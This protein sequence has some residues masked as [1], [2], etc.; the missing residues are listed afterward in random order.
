[1]VENEKSDTALQ[2]QVETTERLLK[3]LISKPRITAVLLTKPPVKFI[4]DIFIEVSTATGCGQGLF[5]TAEMENMTTSRENKF[6]FL[7]ILIHFVAHVVN[8]LSLLQE[9]RAVKVAAG[10]EP[11]KTNLLFQKFCEAA[12]SKEFAHRWASCIDIART[13]A[14]EALRQ[15]GQRP[16]ILTEEALKV[17]DEADTQSPVNY[18]SPSSPSSPAVTYSAKIVTPPSGKAPGH[19]RSNTRRDHRLATCPEEALKGLQEASSQVLPEAKRKSKSRPRDRMTCPEEM[20]R[21]IPEMLCDEA[22]SSAR[23]SRARISLP[24]QPDSPSSHSVLLG[25]SQDWS[26]LLLAEGFTGYE[27]GRLSKLAGQVAQFQIAVRQLVEVAN[28]Q[29]YLEK[30]PEAEFGQLVLGHVWPCVLSRSLASDKS[31]PEAENSPDPAGHGKA[32]HQLHHSH[33]QVEDGHDRSCGSSLHADHHHDVVMTK[34]EYVRSSVMMHMKN[35]QDIG[36]LGVHSQNANESLAHIQPEFDAAGHHAHHAQAHHAIKEHAIYLDDK[37]NGKDNGNPLWRILR[38]KNGSELLEAVEQTLRTQVVDLEMPVDASSAVPLQYA[39]AYLKSPGLVK[40]L[41]DAHADVKITFQGLET[42]HGLEPGQTVLEYAT[43][44]RKHHDTTGHGFERWALIEEIVKSEIDRIRGWQTGRRNTRSMTWTAKNL[45]ALGDQAAQ[46]SSSSSDESQV[47]VKTKNAVRKRRASEDSGSTKEEV[48]RSLYTAKAGFLCEHFEC[49]PQELYDMQVKVGEGTFGS[50]WK[51]VSKQTGNLRAI[52]AIP[53]LILEDLSLWSEIAIMRQLDHPHIMKLFATFEDQHTVYIVSELCCGGQLFDAIIEAGNL[54]ERTAAKMMKQILQAVCYLH[55]RKI[56]HRDLKPEN[57][58]L[59]AR[60]KTLEDV[61]VKLIDFGTAKR[62]DLEEMTTKVCTVHYVAPDLLKNQPVPYTEK[63]DVWSC[64]VILFVML[65]GSPPFNGETDMEVLKKVKKGKFS[66][67]PADIW[68]RVSQDARELI[69]HMLMVSVKARYDA[70]KAC[71]DDW[72][73][74]LAPNSR[75]VNLAN[76]RILGKMRTFSCYNKLKKVALQV[77]AQQLSDESINN[78]RQM[79]VA[80]D[81]ENVGALTVHQMEEAFDQCDLYDDM[82]LDLVY[83]MHEMAADTGEINYTQFLAA[84]IDRQLYLREEACKA[85]FALFDVDGDGAISREDLELLFEADSG[86]IQDSLKEADLSGSG[87]TPHLG[88]S[89]CQLMGVKRAEIERI[90]QESDEDGNGSISFD[91]F[92]KMMASKNLTHHLA[93][94]AEEAALLGAASGGLAHRRSISTSSLDPRISAIRHSFAL[95]EGRATPGSHYSSNR[96]AHEDDIKFHQKPE[97]PM[98]RQESGGKRVEATIKKSATLV[99]KSAGSKN[100]LDAEKDQALR[101][102]NTQPLEADAQPD[103]KKMV[104]SATVI[105]GT[106]GK[107][108]VGQISGG[109]CIP[110]DEEADAAGDTS[111]RGSFDDS[112]ELP[113]PNPLWEVLKEKQIDIIR[114]KAVLEDESR[115]VNSWLNRDEGFPPA[116]FYAVILRLP[117]MVKLLINARA[118]VRKKYEGEKQWRSIRPGQTP[119]EV[120]E[121]QKGRYVGTVLYDR[122]EAVESLMKAEEDRLRCWRSGRRASAAARRY[123]SNTATVDESSSNRVSICEIQKEE[124]KILEMLQGKVSDDSADT[125]EEILSRKTL[126]SAEATFVCQHISGDPREVYDVGEQVGEGTFGT[127]C[128]VWEKATGLERAMKTVPKELLQESDLWQEIELM[129]GMDHPLVAR[130][131]RTY[132]DAE[133]I[134][135]IMEHLSGGELFDA[136]ENAGTFSETTSATVF[137]Q[138]LTAV[139]YIHSKFVCHRDL[140]PENFLLCRDGPVERSLVKLIDFGTA[141]RYSKEDPMTTKICTIHYV[142]PEILV[143]NSTYTEKCDTWSLGVCLYLMLCGGPPFTGETDTHTL[144]KVRKGK[145]KFEPEQFWETIHEDAKGLI[146]ALLVVN[147]DERLSAQ[148]ALRHG[149]LETRARPYDMKINIEQVIPHLLRFHGFTWFKRKSMELVANQLPEDLVRDLW[150]LWLQLDV[151]SRSRLRYMD[152]ARAIPVTGLSDSLLQQ[153]AELLKGM[154]EDKRR[155]EVGYTSFLAAMLDKENRLNESA[156]KSAFLECDL[157]NDSLIRLP[158]LSIIFQSEL[159]D[160]DPNISGDRQLEDVMKA[161]SSG[162]RVTTEACRQLLRDYDHDHDQAI[163]FDEFMAM[164]REDLN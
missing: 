89:A 104:K 87:E 81:K 116:L 27:D 19:R 106:R 130:L 92:V 65:C 44:K 35:T 38:E 9:V 53:K 128:R 23:G 45:A 163:S 21:G 160:F 143:K 137:K 85:A 93:S 98:A 96:S 25:A 119:L 102:G 70:E 86:S 47:K 113:G 115:Y 155:S 71:M 139:A 61:H 2:M 121:S 114:L 41:V 34:R 76:S 48:M 118:D 117:E 28:E 140:K 13:S 153:R 150:Q 127:V 8:D 84:N 147:P 52:K 63:C 6:A 135:M 162:D 68:D 124:A 95:R 103:R 51:S 157:D 100:N 18:S 7:A 72:V 138:M 145:F 67:L 88:L 29:G 69:G 105:F 126:Y 149:W 30:M 10:L 36:A 78:L 101:R 39:T 74:K 91:E 83:M 50:V 79:F 26:K 159:M 16:S 60:C 154:E 109:D 54:S 75:E 31:E 99:L 33:S 107:K 120:N 136:I 37:I 58:M 43:G 90:M 73:C 57:F 15:Q 46:A 4:R 42:W 22:S 94:S 3:T 5:T 151:G 59:V 146:S 49:H 152:I 131:F 129:R 56:C 110:H 14:Q 77:I 24:V 133:N 161:A 142:A 156:C 164:L 112:V 122:C 40:L 111:R 32:G 108:N 132:E 11:E 1:M 17:S 134:H 12:M 62:F 123:F 66:F 148:Q 20:L 55:K 64:G 82:R 97:S 144:K 158:E 141:R 80:L 125:R